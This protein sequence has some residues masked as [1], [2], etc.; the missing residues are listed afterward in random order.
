MSKGADA[1]ANVVCRG[2]SL[3]TW[4]FWAREKMTKNKGNGPEDCTGD[5]DA[6][7]NPDGNGV[8]DHPLV[9]Q[10]LSWRV[11]GLAGSSTSALD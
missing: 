8:R 2:T 5:G 6:A 11:Q 3:W 10:A 4:C 1:R 7:I 9:R